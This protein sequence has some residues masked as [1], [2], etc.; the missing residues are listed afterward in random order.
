MTGKPMRNRAFRG[1]GAALL[2]VGL[3]LGA[4]A[5]AAGAEKAPPKAGG[6][7]PVEKL[8][9]I[10]ELP[11]PFLMKS[12]Q[13]V[14]TRED[15]QK[16][17]EE[18][19]A[20]LAHYEYG[21]MPP[22]PGNVTAEV[23]SSGKTRRHVKLSMG[24]GKKLKM[25]V[26]I[27]L[28]PGK[29]PFPVIVKP[30]HYSGGNGP[31][32]ARRGY[33]VAQYDNCALDPDKRDTVGIAQAAYPDYD[34]GTIAV[35]AWGGMRVIDYLVTLDE[36]DKKK[37]VVTGHSR[38]GKTALLT[39]AYDER[40][41]LTV[42]NGAGGGG[43]Q[44]WRFPI[45]PADPRGRKRHESVAAF[46]PKGYYHWFHPRMGGFVK[47][48]K[49]LPF[50]QHFLLALVAPRAL[51]ST[52]AMDDGCATPICAQRSY[53]G[54]RMV[55][56][57]LGAGGKIGLHVRPQGGH[58]QGPEDWAALLDFAD[59]TFFGKKPKGGQ[60]FGKLPYPDAKPGFSW[61]APPK[62]K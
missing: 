5:A 6:F 51:C 28:P 15:W 13:R 42:P 38:G 49:R 41:A 3:A 36:V 23:T 54:A 40:V 11:D 17:R 60:E 45:W 19:K 35:W 57:W 59:L 39:G 9:E 30:K 10:K 48:E 26:R 4:A 47:K 20:L 33:I 44:C 43:L 8:P 37:I 62:P 18:I 16:R 24:P 61:K 27:S 1:A 55:Y 46:F 56:D 31:E 14:K 58:K 2:L 50:D 25:G 7:P 53:Q 34:W 21:R 32:S 12:G 22:P 52:E 29:G